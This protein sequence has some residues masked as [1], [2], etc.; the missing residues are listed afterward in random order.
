M[1][2][3]GEIYEY[4]LYTSGNSLEHLLLQ[5][6]KQGIKSLA[7]RHNAVPQKTTVNVLMYQTLFSFCSQIK[8]WFSGLEFKK[9]L[10]E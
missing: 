9:V 8:G 5:P 10:S 2:L 6:K 1:E 4:S 3:E 7:Q